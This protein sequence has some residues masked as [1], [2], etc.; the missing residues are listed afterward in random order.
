MPA[1]RKELNEMYRLQILFFLDCKHWCAFDKKKPKRI[2]PD[3]A[4]KDVPCIK[5]ER[6]EQ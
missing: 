1:E 4:I 5:V 3:D 2:K 6:K